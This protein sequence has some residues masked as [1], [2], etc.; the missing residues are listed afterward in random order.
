MHLAMSFVVCALATHRL[1]SLFANDDGPADMIKATRER[2]EKLGQWYSLAKFA[3]DLMSC[4]RC[5]SI[6]IGAGFGLVWSGYNELH[7]GAGLVA[8]LGFSTIAI[9]IDKEIP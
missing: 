3:G 7:W 4:I 6:W 1:G 2:L 9:W 8:G 5:N